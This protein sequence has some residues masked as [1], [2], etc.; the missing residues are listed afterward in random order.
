MSKIAIF[1]TSGFAREVADVCM[2]QG[3]N[4]IVFI[5]GEACLESEINNFP[6]VCESEVDVLSVSGY[7]FAMGI[8]DSEIREKVYNNFLGLDFPNIVHSS[9]VMGAGQRALLDNSSGNIVAAGCVFTNS[10]K[11]GHFGV[12]NLKTTVGHDCILGDFV[13]IMPNVSIS[14]NVEIKDKVF[15]GVSATV[16][17]GKVGSK[18]TLGEGAIVGA[19]SLITKSVLPNTT[20]FGVPAKK[21]K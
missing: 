4:E 19:Q 3:Y 21:I 7:Q 14:G 13:S 9:V 6:V 17:Q 16:L 10:I 5:S 8:G 2:D 11:F 1:G 20:V 15:I 12:F 18:L